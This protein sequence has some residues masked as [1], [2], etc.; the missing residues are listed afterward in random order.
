MQNFFLIFFLFILSEEIEQY[1][2]DIFSDSETFSI[3]IYIEDTKTFNAIADLES[4]FSYI[5]DNTLPLT[6]LTSASKLNEKLTF[7][8]DNKE[9]TGIEVKDNANINKNSLKINDFSFIIYP[10]SF[11]KLK[12]YHLHINIEKTII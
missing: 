1:F 4:E 7:K 5:D 6:S 3:S 11:S 12:S 2:S 8:I 10:S 9:S